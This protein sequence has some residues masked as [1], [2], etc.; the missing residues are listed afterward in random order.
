MA[1]KEEGDDYSRK[2]KPPLLTKEEL[3]W[4]KSSVLQ[5]LLLDVLERDIRTMRT[6]PLKMPDPYIANLRRVQGEVISELTM[7][8]KQ[9]RLNGIKLYAQERTLA[10]IDVQ[11]LCRGYD[12]KF[13][14]LWA[15][16]KAEIKTK[17]CAYF[18]IDVTALQEREDL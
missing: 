15:F 7:L 9:L 11:Y 4:V 2:P 5:T 3:D 8:R 17:L 1:T 6:A 12:H 13:S 10:G 18:A 14:M 16:V